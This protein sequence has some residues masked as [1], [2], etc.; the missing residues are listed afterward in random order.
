MFIYFFLG[1]IV[2]FVGFIVPAKSQESMEIYTPIEMPS[3]QVMASSEF[4]G[5]PAVETINGSGIKNRYHQSQNLGRTMWISLP[6]QSETRAHKKTKTGVVWLLYSFDQVRKIDFLEIW[7]HN[8]N[9]HTNRGLQKVYFQYSL[10]GEE[11]HILKN[12]DKDYFIIPKST[13]CK[14]EPADFQLKLP[15]LL[16]K[17]FVITADLKNGNYYHDNSVLTRQEAEEHKQN[18]DIYGLSEIKFYESKNIPISAL[19]TIEDFS[20]KPSQ[21]YRKSPKGPEREFTIRLNDPLYTG[22][23]FII[24]VAGTKQVHKILPSPLGITKYTSV[25]P[26]G[27]M[28]NEKKIS[29]SFF[30]SQGSVKK[31]CLVPAARKWTVYFLPHS[32]VDIGYTHNHEEVLA[33]QW[34]NLEQA[35]HLAET[36][37]DFPEGAKFHWNSEITWPISEYL[38]QHKGTTKSKRL[39]DAIKEGVIGVD[40]SLGSILTG[41]CKQEEITHLFDDA[42]QI[43]KATGVN[44]CTA[45]MSDIPG[46]TWG[47]V[48]SMSQNGI[49]Y[50]SMAPNYVPF[51]LVG[52]SRVGNI[53]PELGD[54][55]FYWES[56]SGKEKILFW[57]ASKGYSFFHSWLE[58]KLAACGTGPIWDYLTELEMKEYPY[59]ITYMRYTIEGDNG[60]PDK[61]MPEIIR[62]WNEKYEYPKFIIGTTK[63]LFTD[64]EEKYGDY[65]PVM[66]G[67]ITPYWEDGAA[68][69]AVELAMNRRS[70]D[71]LNQGEI[72]WS[73]IDKTNYPE[74]D[75]LKGWRNIVLFSE[76]TWGAATSASEPES[77]F[78]KLLWSQ[79]QAF[80]HR[81]DSLSKHLYLSALARMKVHK[82]TEEFVQVFNTQIWQRTDVVCIETQ[83]DLSDKMLIDEEGNRTYLQKKGEN[84]WFF[85]AHDVPPLGSKVYWIKDLE[86]MPKEAFIYQNNTLSNK[87][88]SFCVDTTK[89]AII[90]LKIEG[91]DWNYVAEKGLNQYIYSGQNATH[92]QEID[93]IKDI[94]LVN[95]GPVFATLRIVSVAPGANS[96]IREVTI[97]KDIK[98]IDIANIIDKQNIYENENVRFK[99]SFNIPNSQLKLDIPFEEVAPER[100][101]LPGSNK[102]F[103]CVNNGVAIKGMKHSIYLATTDTPILEIGEMTGEDWM[104]DRKEF[105]AWKN[106]AKHSSTLYSWVMNNSWKTNYKASQGGICRLNYSVIPIQNDSKDYKRRGIEISQPLVATISYS[107][108]PI[109]SLFML[110]GHHEIAVSTIRPCKNSS[111]LLVRLV[112]TSRWPVKSS[113]IWNETIPSKIYECDNDETIKRTFN[114]ES[115]WM[116]PYETLTLKFEY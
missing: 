36:T 16:M 12:G 42:H 5:F 37:S 39:I 72:L 35:I 9:D 32:H 14:E 55:P 96:L 82:G 11:W 27:L 106:V 50:F 102:N 81:A 33:K 80:A 19:P 6:S 1:F 67:D 65:L 18:I 70:S 98:R 66:K 87:I 54:F 61:E 28:E 2:C 10:D 62:A 68:S 99:F 78:T 46:A 77:K 103:F 109:K 95:N 29:V 90:S 21:A 115:F 107:P 100:N 23:Q 31:S 94:K 20:F 83:K 57:S 17:Y 88:L 75:F 3:V 4:P 45:M 112:N 71:R 84:G 86:E 58:D 41:I 108:I 89:G 47:I 91:E 56:G 76:H 24:E 73:L 49:K 63:Q 79:K 93:S 60:P 113:F 59:N 13:G 22:G 15:G 114:G 105:L 104:E 25:F 85:V 52:G 48:T 69:T 34:R 110:S 51:Y 111:N 8:Q 7:N 53:H 44:I 43:E 116:Q 74:A 38:K 26:N 101:Q 92:I 97:Y 40:A 30:S 64:F